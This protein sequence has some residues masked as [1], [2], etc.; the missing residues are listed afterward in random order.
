VID[1]A[2]WK[3][4]KLIEV[5]GQPVRMQLTPDES[6]LVVT[7]I[8]SGEAA[9]VDAKKWTLEKR[10]PIGKRVEGLAID[11]AGKF[12]YAAA[13]ADDKVVK[14]ALDDWKPILE[15]KGGP[16]PDPILVLPR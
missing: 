1:G 7:L 14:F 16:R 13:Q 3:L 6:R 11:R 8:D 2:E 9:L 12:A 15:I 10:L 5:T 4:V